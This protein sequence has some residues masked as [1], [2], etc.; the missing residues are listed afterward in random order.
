MEGGD[1][2]ERASAGA[3]TVRR[4]GWGPTQHHTKGKAPA[5]TVLRSAPCSLGSNSKITV[6]V[7]AL[8]IP[9]EIPQDIVFLNQVLTNMKPRHAEDRFLHQTQGA[10]PSHA[11][12][13][14]QI[15]NLGIW[16]SCRHTS[17]C[18]WRLSNLI[19]SCAGGQAWIL[20]KQE[21][22]GILSLF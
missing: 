15:I 3:V 21:Q 18:F 5:A 22:K 1:A 19:G 11:G 4:A 9:Q 6:R 10:W 8:Y 20:G 16:S 13:S 14:A 7:G 12:L 2:R 17:V